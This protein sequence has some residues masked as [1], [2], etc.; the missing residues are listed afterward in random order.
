MNRLVVKMSGRAFRLP[1]VWS[2]EVLRTIG[3]RFEGD[4][5]NVSGWKDSDKQS[6]R[7]RDYFPNARSYTIS[8]YVG[9]RGGSDCDL[10]FTPL[11][12]TQPLPPNLKRR[13][14]V[15][16]NHTT[17]EHVFE[18]QTAFSNLCEMSRRFVIVVVPFAQE[19]HETKSYGDYWR[20]TPSGLRKL[21]DAN[22]MHMVYSDVNMHRNSGVYV[23][24]V[25]S[26]DSGDVTKFPMRR[27]DR[28]VPGFWIGHGLG[29][30]AIGLCSR[31]LRCA[32]RNGLSSNCLDGSDCGGGPA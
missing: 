27:D 24:A 30:R 32:R 12:L 28:R 8:N 23:L 5:I 15:V 2:N 6:A 13:F 16:F 11:D 29:G 18:V 26:R 4:V 20:I 22:G 9:E 1:R 3:D 21:F 7:Y 10:D 19:V 14:D 25:G 31:I 17:L